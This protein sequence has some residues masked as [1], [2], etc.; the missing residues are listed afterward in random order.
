[1]QIRPVNLL[2]VV[3]RQGSLVLQLLSFGK[4]ELSFVFS[5]CVLDLSISYPVKALL[6]YLLS[7]FFSNIEVYVL[8]LDTVTCHPKLLLCLVVSDV[9]LHSDLSINSGGLCCFSYWKVTAHLLLLP[10]EIAK[11]IATRQLLGA[12][13]HLLFFV[14]VTVDERGP[15]AK[16]LLRQLLLL[17][18]IVVTLLSYLGPI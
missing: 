14:E 16:L 4:F 18:S 11:V 2:S 1:M 8:I 10:S 3:L 6:H 17:T 15:S 12:K 7:V 13:L 9:F 5:Q